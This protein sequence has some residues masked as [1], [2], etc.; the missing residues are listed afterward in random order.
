MAVCEVCRLLGQECLQRVLKYDTGSDSW[1]EVAPMP[2]AR[3]WAAV[4]AVD[5]DIYVIGGQNNGGERCVEVYKYNVVNNVWSLVS[6]MPSARVNHKA[7]VLG[8]MIYA[9]GGHVIFPA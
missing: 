1:S 9:A 5:S 8:G 6:P 2:A 3:A 4:C 7:C